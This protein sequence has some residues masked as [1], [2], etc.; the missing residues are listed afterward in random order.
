MPAGVVLKRCEDESE[1]RQAGIGEIT[2]GGRTYGQ[3]AGRAWRGWR[4]GDDWLEEV[5]GL[6]VQGR[7][8]S[9]ARLGPRREG[10]RGAGGRMGFR[11]AAKWNK[12][13]PREGFAPHGGGRAGHAGTE[14]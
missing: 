6:K 9:A 7:R 3:G 5:E 12:G 11:V 8:S 14:T 4:S 2:D 13:P 10:R 1:G